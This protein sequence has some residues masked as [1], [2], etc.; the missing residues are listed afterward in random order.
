VSF[1]SEIESDSWAVATVLLG[2]ISWRKGLA[3]ESL[4]LLQ[5]ENF[6]FAKYWTPPSPICWIAC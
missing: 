1:R 5:P 3:Q 4:N 6:A 2:Q